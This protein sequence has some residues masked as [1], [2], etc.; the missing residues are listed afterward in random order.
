MWWFWKLLG[1]ED[2]NKKIIKVADLLKAKDYLA[3]KV[4]DG[5]GEGWSDEYLTA[6]V[7]QNEVLLKKFADATDKEMSQ[8]QKKQAKGYA[9]DNKKKSKD[10]VV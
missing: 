10:I 4:K 7:E 9:K 5:K 6:L 2:E 8:K 3:Q 1:Y